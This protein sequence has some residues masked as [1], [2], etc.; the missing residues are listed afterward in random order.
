M[1]EEK[2]LSIDDFNIDDYMSDAQL[3]YFKQKLIDWKNE[4]LKRKQIHY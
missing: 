1:S 3:D 2:K 4:I